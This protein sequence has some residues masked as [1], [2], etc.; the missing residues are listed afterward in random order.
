VTPIRRGFKMNDADN[1][2]RYAELYDAFNTEKDYAAEVDF[3]LRRKLVSTEIKN[4]LDLGCGTG[5]HANAIANLGCKV[6]AIDRSDQMIDRALPHESVDYYVA[7]ILNYKSAEKFDL[8][9]S[10]FHVFSYLSDLNDLKLVLMNC[11]ENLATNGSIFFD[12]WYTPA[13]MFQVPAVRVKTGEISKNRTAKRL[14]NIE[15]NV[16]DKKVTVSFDFYLHDNANPVANISHFSEV[17][18]MRHFD[19]TEIEYVAKS[20][21]LELVT[22]GEMLTDN[23]LGR[24]TWNA[25]AILRKK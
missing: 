19:I 4:V 10:F 24:N 7:N 21:G 6:T 18:A 8:I 1:F 3:V 23:R 12:F 25:Y 14:T 11:R 22:F 2:Q 5:K 13:V 15:E 9:T 16:V 20:V 17:H